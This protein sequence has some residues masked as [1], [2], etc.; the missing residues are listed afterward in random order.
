[1]RGARAARAAASAE[2]SEAEG[3]VA[4]E[5]EVVVEVTRKTSQWFLCVM[6]S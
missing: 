1:M 3:E 5:G 6:V 4:V 2:V